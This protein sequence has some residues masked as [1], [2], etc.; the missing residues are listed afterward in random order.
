MYRET[1]F[2]VLFLSQTNTTLSKNK[3]SPRFSAYGP[4]GAKKGP[5]QAKIFFDLF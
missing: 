1:F 5:P 3:T 2:F 4:E